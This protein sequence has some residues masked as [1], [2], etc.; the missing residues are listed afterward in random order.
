[1]CHTTITVVPSSCLLTAVLAEQNY[2]KL[3]NNEAIDTS[4]FL[5][6]AA[7]VESFTLH[8][9]KKWNQPVPTLDLFRSGR[10]C[11]VVCL[12]TIVAGINIVY[13]NMVYPY[14]L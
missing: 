14:L 2:L 10:G 6:Y 3:V 13:P 8:P 12:E 5:S 7:S 9:D 11:P 4:Q 1:M